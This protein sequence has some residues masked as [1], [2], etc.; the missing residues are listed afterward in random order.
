M[1]IKI[2]CI[3]TDVGYFH[4][5]QIETN[6]YLKNYSLNRKLSLLSTVFF[7]EQ[8]QIQV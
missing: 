3:L 8:E 4:L 2:K 1:L 6:M 7:Q 5:T